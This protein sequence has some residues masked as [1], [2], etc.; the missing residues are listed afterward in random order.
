MSDM[1]GIASNAIGAY[2]RALSTVSNNIANVNTEGYSRQDVVLKD[3][4]P[5]KMAS[6]FIGTGVM[7]QN[8]K[9]QYDEFAES[10]LRNSTSDL[11]SQKPMVDYAKRVMDIMGDKTIGLSSALDNFF[12]AAGALS[13]DPASTV[14]RTSFLRSAE[15]VASRFGELSTQVGLISTE[16]RQGIESVAAQ[17]NTLTSQLALINQGLAKSPTADTQPAELLDRR[18]LTLRQLS[19]LTRIKVSFTTNGTVNVSVGSTMKEGLVVDGIKARPIGVNQKIKDKVELVLDP[20]GQTETLSS[21][22]G[23]MLGGYQSFISQVL[24]PTEKN[25]SALA[26]TFVRETNTI[27]KSGIDGYGQMG[28]DLFGFDQTVANKASGVHLIINDGMRVATAAQ[29]RVSEGNSNVTT[30]RATVKFTGATPE[31]ALSNTKFV[32]NPNKSAALT[33]KVDG[34]NV[35]TPVSTVSAGVAATFYMDQAEPGQ[36][37]QVMTRDG[38]QLLGQALSETEKYQ[39]LKPSNGFAFNANYS[40]AYLNKSGNDAYR[41]VDMFYGAKATVLYEQ[42]FDTYGALGIPNPMS[43]VMETDRISSSDTQ[44]EAGAITLNGVAMSKFVSNNET[45]IL[46]SGVS[47]GTASTDFTFQAVVGGKLISKNIPAPATPTMSMTDLVSALNTALQSE[48]LTAASLNNDADIKITDAKGRDVNGVVF[49]PASTADGASGGMASINSAAA[50]FADWLNGATEATIVAPQFGASA[51]PT[52]NPGFSDFRGTIAGVPVTVDLSTATNLSELAAQLQSAL[53][54][55]DKSNDLSVV[56]VGANLRITDKQGRAFDQFSLNPANSTT[57]ASG[58]TITTILS[59][60][61]QTN[62]RAE[63]FSEI[64]VPV[65]QLQLAKPLMIN[66]QAIQGFTTSDELVDRINKSEAGVVASITSGGELLIQ[67][68]LGSP[69][70]INSSI[71][72]NALNIQATTYSG[73]VRMVKMVR[74]LNIAATDIDVKKPLQIN[75]VNFSEGVYDF[76]DA[77]SVTSYSVDFGSPTKSVSAA[78]A[79]DLAK[80]VNSAASISGIAFPQG[81]PAVAAFDKFSLDV[82]GKVIDMTGLTAT[83]LADLRTEIETNL[84]TADGAGSGLSVQLSGTM[85]VFTDTAGRTLIPSALKLSEVGTLRNAVAGVVDESFSTNYQAV[86][87]GQR[88]TINPLRGDISDANINDAFMVKADTDILTPQTGINTL[89]GLVARINAKNDLSGV[90]AAIDENGDLKLSTTDAKG[91]LSISI[92]PGKDAK[93]NFV[94]NALG[95]DPLDYNKT[96]R[97]KRALLDKDFNKDIRLS[98]GS[99]QAGDPP[100]ETF[101]DPSDLSK[102]GLRTGVYLEQGCPEDLLLFVTGKGAANVAVGFSGEPLSARDNM[103]SQSLLIKFTAEDRFSI[104]DSN[105]GTELADR[106]YDP[107]VLEPII[108]FQGLQIKLS[109]SPAVGDS[110]KVDGNFDGLGNNVNMLDMVDLNK[111]PV[112]GGKTIANTYIDQINSVG[113]LAQQA[114]ITQQALQVV[115]D[116]AVSAR[117][118]VS[119]VNLDD[120]AAALIRYQQAYQASAKA[121]QVSGQLFDSIVQIR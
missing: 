4:A 48:G 12:A 42:N 2:Q 53:R 5:K 15:G 60:V 39:M 11:S 62:V 85:L 10:N 59:N 36:Q 50:Q 25:L 35:Y 90:V 18:D 14:Q 75:G 121:L 63:V 16:T 33:F 80:L 52:I 105:T 91:A 17:I 93:G 26:E 106:H 100:V 47:V 120:E 101:G 56:V 43:S 111:K 28:Q 40:S 116:Q 3:S 61:S 104:I 118:K 45:D 113:N 44:I 103:R 46:L 79:E 13:A 96:E 108:D 41:G 8:I 31:T 78:S 110:Y 98:F 71:E 92:G 66:G 51:D 82:G 27:Q 114:I 49:T 21:T 77:A 57:R 37:L 1:L 87:D 117:D 55:K 102:L 69:I 83:N 84:Q 19:D 54:E 22:S 94:P 76:P 58:G 20:Y 30:T 34:A 29:F 119:G 86:V 64:R 32:N 72:G 6:M 107:S 65:T 9:R 74:D 81:L 23:G 99:Y 68:P 115:N 112:N 95:L 89:R 38:R 70:R 109:H 24:E 73:Q 97:L 7:L 88:F 67:D